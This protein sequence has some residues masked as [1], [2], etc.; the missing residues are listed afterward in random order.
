[1]C[2]CGVKDY[3]ARNVSTLT[4]SLRLLV[5]TASSAFNTAYAHCWRFGRT[6][7]ICETGTQR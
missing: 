6:G 3:T 7:V 4:H 1:M 2:L 5:F